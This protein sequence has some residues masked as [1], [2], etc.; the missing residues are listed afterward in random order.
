MAEE[1]KPVETVAEPKVVET[2]KPLSEP[3]QTPTQEKKS[4]SALPK[5]LIIIVVV[6]CA[7]VVCS[8]AAFVALTSIAG[9]SINLLNQSITSELLNSAGGAISNGALNSVTNQDG[10]FTFS[11]GDQD[12][13]FSVGGTLPT[14]FPSD[15][16]VYQGAEVSFSSSN[17]NSS[18]KQEVS[19]TFSAKAKPSELVSF[20]KSELT[21]N[22]YD[23]MGEVSFFGQ[24]LTFENT[25]R[26]VTISAFGD[27]TGQETLLTIVSVEK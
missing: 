2:S 8:V 11:G 14:G 27:E 6:I 20:Y 18:G 23:F 3:N 13:S 24:V 7:C 19:A 4:G 10:G 26:E 1:N 22:G 9:S 16:P 21:S 15:I 12:S 5:I 25:A 17:T